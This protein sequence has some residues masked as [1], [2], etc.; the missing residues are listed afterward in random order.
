MAGPAHPAA[1]AEVLAETRQSVAAA[2]GNLRAVSAAYRRLAAAVEA[3]LSAPMVA[4]PPP[5]RTPPTEL[6]T[7]TSTPR[8]PRRGGKAWK[9]SLHAAGAD[10][11]AG[12]VISAHTTE[13][14]AES[15]RRRYRE[16]WEPRQV[17]AEI[18][19]W[20]FSVLA[21]RDEVL[22]EGYGRAEAKARVA[23]LVVRTQPPESEAIYRRYPDELRPDWV[24]I[25]REEAGLSE[26]LSSRWY[27]GR[28]GYARSA[29]LG[30]AGDHPYAA[31]LLEDACGLAYLGREAPRQLGSLLDVLGAFVAEVLGPRGETYTVSAGEI[32]AWLQAR[33]VVTVVEGAPR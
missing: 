18:A 12:E 6:V 29:Y 17:K 25:V 22:A 7:V 11:A 10:P 31:H 14:A 30:A 24:H 27:Q 4:L 2:L 3:S 32:L 8:R 21:D 5:A 20:A 26:A 19:R 33:E 13:G 1:L 28:E 23:R 15:A 16:A 9:V